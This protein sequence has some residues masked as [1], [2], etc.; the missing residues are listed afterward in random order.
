MILLPP[1]QQHYWVD[2]LDPWI[3]HFSGNFGIRWYGL[4]YAAGILVAAWLFSRWARQGRL[5]VPVDQVGVL[6]TYAATGV[7]VGG[8][9]G[10]CVFYNAQEVIRHPLEIFAVW[11]GGMA[12]H[13]GILGLVAALWR[14]ARRHRIDPLQ[15]L[16]AAA[17]VGPLGIAFGR[18]ANFINGELYGHASTVPWAV[19]FPQEIYA[20]TNGI[21]DPQVDAQLPTVVS[22]LYPFATFSDGMDLLVKNLQNHQAAALDAVRTILPPRHPSQLY[23]ALLEGVLLFAICYTIG[24]LWRKDGMASGAFLTFYPVMRI[25]GEQFRVGDQSVAAGSINAGVIYSI[26]MI[27]PG[28]LYWIYWIKRDRRIPWV[29]PAAA[30]EKPLENPAPSA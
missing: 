13:G 20:P 16:D 24:R 19:Q 30:P 12:S 28:L 2:N 23:E 17:A 22:H 1:T 18:I 29:S 25:I 7:L 4:S 9:L 27:V 11:H 14:F 21:M 8:R 15:L 5:P 10:Y 6:V 3:M 26:L